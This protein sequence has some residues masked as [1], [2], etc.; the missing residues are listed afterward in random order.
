MVVGSLPLHRRWLWAVL[1]VALACLRAPRARATLDDLYDADNLYGAEKRS[2]DER[3]G[4]FAREWCN[5][6]RR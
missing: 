2:V 4:E 5:S 1:A 6:H 3:D